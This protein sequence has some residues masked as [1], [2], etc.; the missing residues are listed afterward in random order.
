MRIFVTGGT[1][2]IG[3][4]VVR[5]LVRAGH[6]VVGLVRNDARAQ[7][8][9]SLGAQPHHG[10]LADPAGWREALERSDAAV[11]IAMEHSALTEELDRGVVD[12]FLAASQADG[13]PRQLVYTSGVLVLGAIEHGPADERATTDHAL[14]MV[15]W[16]P[17]HEKRLL[18]GVSDGVNAAVIRPGFVYGGESDLMG[19]Y[20]ASAEERGAS[21][22]IGDGTN[23][24]AMVYLGD[25][26][27]LYRMVIEKGARGIFH[28]VDE[29]PAR[30]VDLA[31]AAS[32]A[33]GRGGA[34]R[35]IPLEEARRKMGPFAD[36]LCI[37]Q[38]VACPRAHELGWR[39]SR[40]VLPDGVR[41][42]YAEWKASR[43]A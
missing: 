5:T 39:A 41:I 36:A 22:F 8:L 23:H 19:R 29:V 10:D 35:S 3:K 13:G 34:T 42:A 9:L 40:P 4:A 12:A 31:T 25:I 26:A 37:N 30:I 24:M 6:E 7:L 43:G 18:D 21:E 15:A 33:A 27:A 16:R 11:H 28:G 1:G 38:L 17:R 32:E 2:Y 14:Q 20:F